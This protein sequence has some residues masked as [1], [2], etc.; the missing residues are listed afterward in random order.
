M[1]PGEPIVGV[2]QGRPELN[3]ALRSAQQFLGLAALISVL[4]AGVAV[5]T[6]ANRFSLRHL[7]TSA[8]M[9]CLGATQD[10]II[11]LFMMEM[12]WLSLLASSIGCVLGLLTQFVISGLLDQLLLTQLPPPSL[13]A[14]ILGYATGM[15]MLVGF[16]MPPLLS[17]R[18]V[19]TLHVLRKDLPVPSASIWLV[20]VAV[21]A[22]MALLLYWQIADL[23]LV[24]VVIGGTIATLLTL[25]AAAY[26]LILLLNR[27]RSRVAVAWRFG[28][29]NI[30]RRAGSSVIQIVAFGIG[31]MVLLLL[32]T[33]RTDLLDNWQRTLPA[34]APNY[35]IVNVQS[36]QVQA[37]TGYFRDMGVSNTTPV[38]YTHLTLPTI[39]FKCRSRWA[40]DQ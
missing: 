12:I 15:V 20:Y 29:A 39:C 2:E 3:T 27:V 4:L 5:A 23:K 21:I 16:A 1:R 36:E 33:V 35:F 24:T 40:A 26:M 17:L 28:L 19:P 30:S 6:V 9:R 34:D 10:T 38:S 22:C 32:S 25:A 8:M 31:I 37:I 13:N 14:L 18:R 11:R 7:D